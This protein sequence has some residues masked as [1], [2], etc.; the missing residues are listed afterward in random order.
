MR[1]CEPVFLKE[2]KAADRSSMLKRKEMKSHLFVLA[3][4]ADIAQRSKCITLGINES[5]RTGHNAD[6]RFLAAAV[7]DRACRG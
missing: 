5:D 2:L 1:V 6:N 3:L 4:A 7:A